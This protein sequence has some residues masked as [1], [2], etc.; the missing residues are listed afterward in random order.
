MQRLTSLLGQYIV[1]TRDSV[2]SLTQLP[3]K[4]ISRLEA[5]GSA[6]RCISALVP[7]QT[8][9]YASVYPLD[10]YLPHTCAEMVLTEMCG[11]A[12]PVPRN[13]SV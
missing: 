4:S 2:F 9:A 10:F 5:A 13:V 6:R 7:I 3:C 12:D 8:L 11:S 1:E